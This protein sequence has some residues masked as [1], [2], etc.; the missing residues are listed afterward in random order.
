MEADNIDGNLAALHKYEQQQEANER[1]Y[2]ALIEMIREPMNE[3]I[4]QIHI[5]QEIIDNSGFDLNAED[6]LSEF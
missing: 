5:A 3:A 2:D 6:L 1:A 4:E